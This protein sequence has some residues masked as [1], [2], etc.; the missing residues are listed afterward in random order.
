MIEN[1]NSGDPS[2]V[3]RY[4]STLS[5]LPPI[6]PHIYFANYSEDHCPIIIHNKFSPRILAILFSPKVKRH[7]EKKTLCK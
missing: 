2:S 3:R 7:L 4:S 1:N 5:V 6:L